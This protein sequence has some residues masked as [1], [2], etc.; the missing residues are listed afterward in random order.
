MKTKIVP[1]L[2]LSEK[3]LINLLFEK[4]VINHWIIDNFI[5]VS[6]GFEN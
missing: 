6:N 4:F 2:Y 3:W 1:K 5:I